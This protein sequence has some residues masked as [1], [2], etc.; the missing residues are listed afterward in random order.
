MSYDLYF[1]SKKKLSREDVFG[2]LSEQANAFPSD[3]GDR[4]GFENE[5]T[6]VYFGFDFSE[7]EA[8]PAF[9]INYVRPHI[10]GLEAE[11]VLTAFVR[12]FSLDID[13][14]Q[15][16][17]MG[18]GPYTPEGFL[19]GWNAGNL[20]GY[21]AVL[22]QGQPM[23]SLPRATNHMVWTWNVEREAIQQIFEDELDTLPPAF[24]P[25][26][27]VVQDDAGIIL[28]LSIW[29]GDMPI[30]FAA[31]VDAFAIPGAAGN[32]II[33]RADV[34]AHCPPVAQWDAKR[35]D[36][37]GRAIGTP[38]IVIDQPS[39]A[40]LKQLQKLAVPKKLTRLA[41][42]QVLDR[43]EYELARSSPGK[44]TSITIGGSDEDE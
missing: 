18:K 22:S 12:K 10:F 17:G 30:C 24:T 21:R 23:A 11:P 29:T 39:A 40:T 20:F 7:G 34:L 1:S 14:P 6:G 44:M 43:E 36:S 28:T 15:S 8:L 5:V 19:R 41:I 13:D 33:S 27:F 9:N 35:K 31:G 2:W 25:S 16:D 26:V 37:N 4:V 32:V 38:S 3:A 42:D